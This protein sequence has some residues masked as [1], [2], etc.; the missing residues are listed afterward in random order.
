MTTVIN[1]GG[2]CCPSERRHCQEDVGSWRALSFDDP[3]SPRGL[4]TGLPLSRAA[5]RYLARVVL[6][7]LISRRRRRLRDAGVRRCA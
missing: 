5:A 7:S 4:S 1:L 3:R 2:S 6:E